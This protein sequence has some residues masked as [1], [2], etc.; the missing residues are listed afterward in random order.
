MLDCPVPFGLLSAMPA[1][2]FDLSAPHW[3]PR[4]GLLIERA[5]LAIGRLEARISATALRESWLQRAI[6]TGF[7]AALRGQGAEVDEIDL[8]A[9]AS[10]VALPG[11][12]PIA[13]HLHEDERLARWR[14]EL[15]ERAAP[16]W[17]EIVPYPLA[18]P[19]DWRQRPA[20]LRALELAAHQARSDGSIEPALAFPRLLQALGICRTPLP[21]LVIHDKAW[22]L[23]PRDRDAI[24]HRNLRQLASAAD[25]GLKRLRLLETHR[26]RAASAISAVARPGRLPQL[27]ALLERCPLITPKRLCAS[28]DLTISGAGKLLTRA[29]ELGLVAEISGRQAWKVYLA[30]DLAAEFGF[31]ERP[32]GR[33]P[34]PAPTLAPLDDVLAQFDRELAAIDATLDSFNM[35][36]EGDD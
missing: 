35:M 1:R 17:R 32:R 26:L 28:L 14:D 25:S 24:V 31:V 27:A 7:T 5:A 34:S 29:A 21:C 30:C 20:L 12:A 36:S 6:W 8:F 23:A 33:P 10:A 2:P 19:T 3:T 16:H 13:T 15:R 22:R 18:L 11:R 4:L 9:R